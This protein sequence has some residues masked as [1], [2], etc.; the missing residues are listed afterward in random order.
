MVQTSMEATDLVKH[1][2]L[3]EEGCF[4]DI[5]AWLVATELVNMEHGR[6]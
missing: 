5:V 2:M 1:V 4:L 6:K 3:R